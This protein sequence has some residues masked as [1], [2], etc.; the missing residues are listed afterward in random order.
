MLH[1]GNYVVSFKQEPT[2]EFIKG[3]WSQPITCNGIW[4]CDRCIYTK[5]I[6]VGKIR[7]HNNRLILYADDIWVFT[8]KSFT[9]IKYYPSAV[10]YYDVIV[11][12][13]HGKIRIDY[14]YDASAYYIVDEPTEEQLYGY[15]CADPGIAYGGIFTTTYSTV[16]GRLINEDTRKLTEYRFKSQGQIR[17]PVIECIKDHSI[18][19][20]A[21]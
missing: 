17:L 12:C 15:C 16:D 19:G 1:F 2:T 8:R 7:K 18:T 21:F 11:G 6:T 13:S 9:R 4:Y 20:R 3:Q 5:Y 10:P 14:K